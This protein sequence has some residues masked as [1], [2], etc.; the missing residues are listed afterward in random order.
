M[1]CD[2]SANNLRI[3]PDHEDVNDV[4]PQNQWYRS[5]DHVSNIKIFFFTCFSFLYAHL[6]NGTYYV[7][8]LVSI[9]PGKHPRFRGYFLAILNIIMR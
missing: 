4:S 2:I 7:T 9:R 5:Q 3:L 6:K 8:G 1:L